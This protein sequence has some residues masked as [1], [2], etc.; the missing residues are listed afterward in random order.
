MKGPRTIVRVAAMESG[1]ASLRRAV[2][3][4]AAA[5]IMAV[6][7]VAGAAPAF[8]D[9]LSASAPNCERGQAV[10]FHAQLYN[11]SSND[12]QGRHAYKFQ[13]CEA[14]QP[15]GKGGGQ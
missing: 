14:N 13:G 11:K 6:M 10:A 15:P 12:D 5:L 3:V 1:G 7:L 2:L 4:L 8:A 9:G